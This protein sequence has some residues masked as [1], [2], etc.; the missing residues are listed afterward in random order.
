MSKVI[1]K[2]LSV[3][4]F[5]SFKHKIEFDFSKHH[6]LNYIYGINN[7]IPG[8]KNGVGKS[9]LFDA[10]LFALYGKSFLNN[11]NRF[12]PNRS[13]TNKK[14]ITDVSLEFKINDTEYKVR[15]FIKHLRKPFTIGCQL[16]VDGKEK[17]KTTTKE[18]RKFI[19]EQL[20]K[21]DYDLFKRSVILSSGDVNNFFKM[22]KQE[23]RNYIEDVFDLT[24]F[25]K[26]FA[27]VKKD[28]N[29][30]DKE[31]LSCQNEF[32][33]L[34][35]TLKD[36]K[37]QDAEFDDNQIIKIKSIKKNILD[38]KDKIKSIDEHSDND[39]EKLQGILDRIVEQSQKLSQNINDSK[40]TILK[41]NTDIDNANRNLEKHKEILNIV[42]NDCQKK[43]NDK[44]ELQIFNDKIKE[45]KSHLKIAEDNKILLSK[46][47]ELLKEKQTN[48]QGR[49]KIIE[50][51]E[52]EYQRQIWQQQQHKERIKELA[53]D[54]KTEKAKESPYKKLI[55]EYNDKIKLKDSTIKKFI[56]EKAEL[57]IIKHA[58]SE[59]GAK[60]YII[61]DLVDILNQLVHKYLEEMGAEFTCVF[62]SSFEM[63]F[64]TTTGECEYNS[65][66]AGERQRLTIAV[67]MAFRDI[68]LNGD[69][70]DCNIFV[71]DELLDANVDGYCIEALINILGRNT[72]DE[73]VTF[74][75]SHREAVNPDEFDNIIELQKKDSHTYIA[76]DKQGEIK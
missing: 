33:Q 65:F 43:I 26:L 24:I 52:K 36:M 73:D 1:F 57:E 5:K 53:N 48:V 64:L 50:N 75:I 7:D 40:Q 3:Q 70:F 61:K 28:L 42:C 23:K 32:Q 47:V 20:L 17:S 66:S 30:L 71:L 76:E 37:T 10:L 29:S 14:N 27:M 41:C 59:E 58:T 55:D 74:V 39:K 2:K 60:K 38:L 9:N 34:K 69:M 19:E 13:N 35:D 51:S 4:N 45:S 6:G 44:Y 62:D 72:D 31:L 56:K 8:T 12:L 15:T 49:L 25:G 68:L 21:C 46:K 63:Q 54:I 16:W 18:T 11:K 67:L 22:E